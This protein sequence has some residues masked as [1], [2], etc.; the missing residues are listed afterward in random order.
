MDR[1][2]AHAGVDEE[3]K[4]RLRGL[5]AQADPVLLLA[6]VC[7]AQAVLGERVDRR[8]TQAAQPEPIIVDPDRFAA[9]L[10]TAWREGERRATHRRP[11]R[12]RKPVPKRPSMLDAFHDQIRAWLDREPGLTAVAVLT[13]LKSTCPEQFTDCHLRTVQ[14][15]VKAWRGH[16]A[17]RII[18][19]SA[20]ALAAGV[21]D[22][23]ASA[24][25]IPPPSDP[26]GSPPGAHS[27][28]P[29]IAPSGSGRPQSDA[30]VPSVDSVDDP[31]LPR[32][33]I[34]GN[35]PV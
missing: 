10:K 23:L 17:H 22:P 19:E 20:T 16:Q 4:M 31:T 27:Y 1:V 12:R 29:R 34:P 15:A 5:H 7:A 14:R 21:D 32:H 25:V 33:E 24:H 3:S 2:L 30:R 18:L 9:S 13:R 28:S 6:E 11:Y 26:R 35:I 8:G